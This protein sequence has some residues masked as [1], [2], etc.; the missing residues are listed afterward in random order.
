MAQAATFRV[1]GLKPLLKRLKLLPDRIQRRVLRSAVTKAATPVLKDARRRA[2]VGAGISPDGSERTPLKKSLIKTRAKLRK[3]DG[4]VHVAIGP[5]RKKAPHDRL[6]H[7]GTQPHTITLSQPLVLQN[8]VLPAGT[9]I[10]H[11][12]AKSQPFLAEAVEAQRGKAQQIL[13]KS[14]AAGIEKEVAKLG[15]RK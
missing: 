14:I 15:G 12:G 9:E 3:K 11:P 8:V 10:Q 4:G 2:P 1:T 13:E 7:D 6:V 5:E